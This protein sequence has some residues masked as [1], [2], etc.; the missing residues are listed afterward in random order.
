MPPTEGAGG[1]TIVRA[2]IA[3]LHMLVGAVS[4]LKA[5]GGRRALHDRGAHAPDPLDAVPH[6]D[7]RLGALGGLETNEG[8]NL[9]GYSTS[10]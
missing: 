4:A 9:K 6:R 1:C 3:T 10:L 5:L 2:M 7:Y 8:K